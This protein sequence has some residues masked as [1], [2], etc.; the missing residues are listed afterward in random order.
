MKGKP[1]ACFRFSR[2]FSSRPQVAY[3]WVRVF[4]EMPDNRVLQ[5]VKWNNNQAPSG[6]E[7]FTRRIEGALQ[8][9]QLVVYEYAQ[10]LESSRRGMELAGKSVGSDLAHRCGDNGR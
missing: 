5:R 7:K 9:I 3:F 4:E 8:F 6:T 2:D 1:R 10:C